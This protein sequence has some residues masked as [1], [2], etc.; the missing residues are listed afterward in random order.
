MKRNKFKPKFCEREDRFLFRL[1]NHFNCNQILAVGCGLDL[2]RQYLT[3]HSKEAKCTVTE[4]ATFVDSPENKYDMIVYAA[5]I[6]QLDVNC[7]SKS[8]LAVVADIDRNKPAWQSICSNAN[9]STAIDLG[10]LGLIFFDPK[11]P[12]KIYK[13]VIL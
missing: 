3:A 13:C 11:L 10:S 5:E 2:T 8:R 4:Q 7:L 6:K 12:R 1:A 9:I